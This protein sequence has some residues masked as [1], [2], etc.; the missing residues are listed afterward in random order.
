MEGGL[1]NLVALIRTGAVKGVTSA[2]TNAYLHRY[3]HHPKVIWADQIDR[4][5]TYRDFCQWHEI[6]LS[7]P[8]LGRPKR[9]AQMVKAE[10]QQ[11]LEDQEQRI[12]L[13]KANLARANSGMGWG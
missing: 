9:N 7:G 1:I 2:Q 10:K 6:R 12:T 11:F 3:G 8:R 4:T 13:L 5:R